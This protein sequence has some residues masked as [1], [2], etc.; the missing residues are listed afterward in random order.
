V[1]LRKQPGAKLA[2]VAST[3]G[4]LGAFFA[5]IRANPQIE[6]GAAAEPA[7]PAGNYNEFFYPAGTPAP[8]NAMERATPAARPHTRTRAS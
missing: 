5:L 1:K 8:A 4:L 2:V 6:A 7:R 3:L